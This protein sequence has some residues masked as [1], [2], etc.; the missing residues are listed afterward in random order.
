MATASP[1]LPSWAAELRD[2]FR[3][4]STAQFLLHGNVFDVVPAAGRLFSLKDFLEEVMFAGYDVVLQYDRS[5]GVRATR[6]RPD[7]PCSSHHCGSV[8]SARG[9]RVHR[10]SGN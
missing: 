2:L 6:A 10:P 9:D 3:S 7:I 1:A 4:G 8:R 5:R